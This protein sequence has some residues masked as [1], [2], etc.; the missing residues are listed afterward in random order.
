MIELIEVLNAEILKGALSL[1]QMTSK[2][3]LT[4]TMARLRPR[5]AAIR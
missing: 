4:A 5:F 3:W 1:E 2:A